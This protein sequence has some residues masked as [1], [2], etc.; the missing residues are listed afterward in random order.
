M[1]LFGGTNEADREGND[2]RSKSV[3]MLTYN[4]VAF[5]NINRVGDGKN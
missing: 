2:D 1:S 4:I 3:Y 5:I